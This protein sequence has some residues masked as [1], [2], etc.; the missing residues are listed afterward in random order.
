MVA[1]SIVIHYS[2]CLLYRGSKIIGF[3][4]EKINNLPI[5]RRIIS[6]LL[7]GILLFNWVG[8]RMFSSYLED[9]A[10]AQFE[11]RLDKNEY[12]EDQLLS[13]KIP[14]THLP[15]YTNS[16]SFDRVNGEIEMQGML[17]KYVKRRIFNDSIE[18][19]CIRDESA[20][21]LHSA[22]DDFFKLINGLQF[23][24]SRHSKKADPHKAVSKSFCSDNYT[25]GN[26]VSLRTP[27]TIL[28]KNFSPYLSA[29][30]G[31]YSFTPE[32]PPRRLLNFLSCIGNYLFRALMGQGLESSAFLSWQD[33]A[34]S[35][36]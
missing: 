9:K 18:L 17:Y 22:K 13:I 4:L 8:Y 36:V 21:Q 7:L 31:A 15:Y 23:N 35:I 33:A 12:N 30:T 26:V 3:I 16:K 14:V 10:N 19:L 1:Q 34:K 25:L 6:I 5:L 32:R 27:C 20:M 24:D 28:S 11:A 29:I 2:Y